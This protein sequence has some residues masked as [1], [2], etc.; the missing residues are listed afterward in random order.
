MTPAVVQVGPEEPV[1]VSFR[2]PAGAEGPLSLTFS[3]DGG[4]RETVLVRPLAIGVRRVEGIRIDG[5]LGDW[6]KASKLPRRL[7]T[8]EPR[9]FLPHVWLGWSP[10]GLWLAAKLSVVD[11]R[12]GDPRSFWDGTSVEL[13]LDAFHESRRGW[14]ETAHQFWFTPVKADGRWRLYA[15]EWKRSEAIPATIYDD[16]RCETG[17]HVDG[18]VV[19]VEA[20]VPRAALRGLAL[21]GGSAW[22]ASLV[23]Q[24]AGPTER[25][26]F[27]WPRR[28]ED[29]LLEGSHRWGIARLRE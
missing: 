29:G 28:K 23:V 17:I 22:R 8:S 10:K 18:A 11:L 21:E 19:A 7:L 20:F 4:V 12:S 14:G 26:S 16:D 9:K 25:A 13:F 2:A 27:A 1:A 24:E 15:G 3:L 6:P 5:Q